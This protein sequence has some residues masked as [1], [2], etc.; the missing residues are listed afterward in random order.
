MH[1]FFNYGVWSEMLNLFYISN[2]SVSLSIQQDQHIFSSLCEL[3]EAVQ[4]M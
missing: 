3:K 2:G 1:N 4:G